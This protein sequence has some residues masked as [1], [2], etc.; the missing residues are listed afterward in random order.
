MFIIALAEV[1]IVTVSA[2][3]GVTLAPATD[4][5]SSPLALSAIVPLAGR[6]QGRFVFA[7]NVALT[8][9][10]DGAVTAAA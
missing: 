10:T 5:V 4:T 7:T 2:L 1:T 9:L 8:E 3:C 6:S